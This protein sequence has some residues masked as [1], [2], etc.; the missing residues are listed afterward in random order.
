V[1]KWLASRSDDLAAAVDVLVVDLAAA[2]IAASTGGEKMDSGAFAWDRNPPRAM[3]VHRANE[4]A[5]AAVK[6]AHGGAK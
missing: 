6:R 5:T 2:E 4:I 1:T 3:I